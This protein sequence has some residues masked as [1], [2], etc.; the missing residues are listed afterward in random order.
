MNSLL[1]SAILFL[2]FFGQTVPNFGGTWKLDQD[3]STGPP[4]AKGASF[5]IITQSGDD[6]TFEYHGS[7]N[8]KRGDLI[9]TSSYSTDGRE[10]QGNK[11][12]T[13]VNYV[14]SYWHGKTLLVRTRSVMDL[15]GFQTFTLED[16][17]SLSDDGKTLTD[18]S[19]D[20]TKAVYVRQ[21]DTEP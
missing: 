16:R 13:Y 19:S 9:Q 21:P 6:L 2:A 14:R 12:R 17:W 10:R 3:A 1:F 20:G 15:D 11:L 7:S 8:G 18:Q 5:L 4:A